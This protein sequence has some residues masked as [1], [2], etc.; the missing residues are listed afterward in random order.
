MTDE[1][2]HTQV[3]D[4]GQAYPEQAPEQGGLDFDDRILFMKDEEVKAEH[5]HHEGNEAY[6]KSN[7]YH[8]SMH[9]NCLTKLIKKRS[10]SKG[11]LF[12]VFVLS[13][14]QTHLYVC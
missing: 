3:E 12:V 4:N 13:L 8:N 14:P 1:V 9:L 7:T 2:V 10:I 6:P 5:D 11:V